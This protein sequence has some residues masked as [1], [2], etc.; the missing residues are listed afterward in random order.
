MQVNPSDKV[1]AT[2]D[3]ING[4]PKSFEV[5]KFCY[6][7]GIQAVCGNHETNFFS[8]IADM[9]PDKKRKSLYDEL[10]EKL[11]K[12]PVFL[13]WLRNL[14]TYIE[15]EHFLL[16]HAGL[17]PGVVLHVQNIADLTRIREYEG[18]PWH[19]FYT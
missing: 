11:E 5:I 6:E 15:T 4:G 18:K 14:A 12:C 9:D 19:D 17:K 7:H 16:V 2:G 8:Y 1:Y 10:S 13:G 3:V